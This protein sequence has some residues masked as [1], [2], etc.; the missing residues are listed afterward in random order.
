MPFTV[1]LQFGSREDAADFRILHD[2]YHRQGFLFDYSKG[3][4]LELVRTA[5]VEDSTEEG[6]GADG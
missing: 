4:I 2:A 1:T 5:E 3:R 6:S